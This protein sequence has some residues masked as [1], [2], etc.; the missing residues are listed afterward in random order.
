MSR[1]PSIGQ[2]DAAALTRFCASYSPLDLSLGYRGVSGISWSTRSKQGAA[3]GRATSR[4]KV[5]HSGAVISRRSGEVK[6][7]GSGTYGAK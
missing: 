7:A 3:G 5:E 6:S 1:K 4:G 2:V